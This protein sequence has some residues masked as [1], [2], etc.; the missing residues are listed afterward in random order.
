MIF[1]TFGPK[2]RPSGLSFLKNR[3]DLLEFKGNPE[4]EREVEAIENRPNIQKERA[5][6]KLYPVWRRRRWSGRPRCP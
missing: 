5:K 4:A 1:A 3:L 2:P 6:F